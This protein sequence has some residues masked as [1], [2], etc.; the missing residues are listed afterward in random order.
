MGEGSEYS[1]KPIAGPSILL[2]LSGHADVKYE[3]EA[4]CLAISR[5]SVLFVGNGEQVKL[6]NITSNEELLVFQAYC[7][8]V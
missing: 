5:G 7:D 2:T 4:G 3:S 1:V 8:L 6:Q